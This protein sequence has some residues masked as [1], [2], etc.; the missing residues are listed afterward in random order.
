M[1]LKPLTEDDLVSWACGEVSE[2]DRERIDAALAAAPARAA[3]AGELK[4]TFEMIQ[5]IEP[6]G[7]A[8]DDF[9]VRLGQRWAEERA[10]EPGVRRPGGSPAA[11]PSR[12]STKASS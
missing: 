4:E 3:A 2:A 7:G 5:R 12:A 8:S 9:G 6:D 10:G 1:N 11:T